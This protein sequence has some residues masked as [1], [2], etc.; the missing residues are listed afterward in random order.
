MA[1][2]MNTARNIFIKILFLRYLENISL[3]ILFSELLFCVSD[4]GVSIYIIILP[5]IDNDDNE[6]LRD[7]YLTEG[8]LIIS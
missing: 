6:R 2:K 4:F 8:V 1:G 5:L 3:N 7:A